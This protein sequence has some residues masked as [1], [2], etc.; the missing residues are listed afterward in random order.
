MFNFSCAYL[1]WWHLLPHTHTCRA[2]K[3]NNG[4]GRTKGELR[5]DGKKR[6]RH[7]VEKLKRCKYWSWLLCRRVL[8]SIVLRY[9]TIQFNEDRRKSNKT[10]TKGKKARCHK[11]STEQCSARME[12]FLRLEEFTQKWA[13][14]K[15]NRS[16]QVD[17]TN[18][19]AFSGYG[20]KIEL[21]LVWD[22]MSKIFGSI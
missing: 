20:M 15:A 1:I 17:D 2:R 22:L 12:H 21:K 9:G 5:V 19:R 18:S 3:Y 6:Q 13:K 4:N 7:S 10:K 11:H 16:L 8:F 14:K